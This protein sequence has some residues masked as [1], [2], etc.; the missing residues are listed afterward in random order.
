[1]SSA[2]QLMGNEELSALL[3]EAR[4]FNSA[5][6]ITGMLLYENGNFMQL[7]EGQ[8]ETVLELYSRIQSDPRHHNIYTIAQGEQAEKSFADW[9]MGFCYMNDGKFEKS[10]DM[11]MSKKLPEINRTEVREFIN[12]FYLNNL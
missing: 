1:M 6:A 4:S 10:L 11:Y 8:K 12:G 5:H 2:N 7:L 3:S 9:S